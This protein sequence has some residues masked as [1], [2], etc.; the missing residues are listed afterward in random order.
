MCPTWGLA[1]RR[2][3]SPPAHGD[4]VLPELPHLQADGVQRD[5]RGGGVLERVVAVRH[6]RK[7]GR[8]PTGDDE[9]GA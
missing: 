7:V 4:E 9:K 8:R 1:P 2:R 6:H 3:T 5:E